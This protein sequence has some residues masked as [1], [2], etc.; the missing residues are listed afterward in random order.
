MIGKFFTFVGI[1]IVFCLAAWGEG[2]GDW[3]PL[4]GLFWLV[5]LVTGMR[6]IWR[7]V[8]TP[9]FWRARR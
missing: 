7:L 9:E 4:W 6:M 5:A 2:S 3:G 1:L 8:T